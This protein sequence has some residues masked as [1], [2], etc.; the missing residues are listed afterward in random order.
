MSDARRDLEFAQELAK[1]LGE[2]RRSSG[3]SQASLAAETG[4]DQAAV[5]RVETAHRRLTVSETL[6]WLDALGCDLDDALSRV[7]EL[8]RRHASRP[9]TFWEDSNG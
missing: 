7:A 2:L 5:S 1:L 6:Q 9:P 8:W 4:L 3:M